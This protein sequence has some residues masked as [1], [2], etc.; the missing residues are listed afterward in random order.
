[1]PKKES[2]TMSDKLQK[3]LKKAMAGSPKGELAKLTDS[4]ED[5]L[6]VTTQQDLAIELG[7]ARETVGKWMREPGAPRRHRGRHNV[8]A[9]KAWME[10]TEKSSSLGVAPSPMKH[11]LEVRKLT[12]VCERLELEQKIRLG[13]YHTN[14]DCTL[15][16]SKAMTSVRTI[17]LALPS[18]MAPVV[19]MRPKE[20]IELLLREAIDEA[21]ISVH[22]REWP[23]TRKS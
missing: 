3:R 20:E 11:E 14:D 4:D 10:E 1:M 19:E 13:Q 6:Y 5:E 21:L 9:W 17:L 18:K 22:E 2:T 7:V 23:S 8:V 12:A 15:W 16:V